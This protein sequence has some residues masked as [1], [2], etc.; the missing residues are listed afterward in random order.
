MYPVPTETIFNS[1]IVVCLCCYFFTIISTPI[2]AVLKP[3]LLYF[4]HA[5]RNKDSVGIDSMLGRTD[6][7][8]M[9]G[10][11]YV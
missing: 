10:R 4:G 8:R 5:I 1:V 7:S 11:Q 6:G 3:N 2:A 9:K